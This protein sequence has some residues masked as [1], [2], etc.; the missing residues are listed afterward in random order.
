LVR[1]A[2]NTGRIYLARLPQPPATVLEFLAGRFAH[3]PKEEWRGR[4][5]RGQV[6]TDTGMLV[7]AQTPYQHGLTILYHRES[8]SEPALPFVETIVFEDEHLLVADKPHFLPVTP[9]G[10]AV[11]ECLLVRLQRR[12]PDDELAPLHRLDRDTAGIVV[13]SKR[14]EERKHYTALFSAHEVTRRYLAVAALDSLSADGVREWMVADR[15]TREPGSF[16]MRSVPGEANASTHVRLIAE[17]EGRG[18]F[19]LLPETGKKHQ[20]RL[21]MLA[22]GFP[23]MNDPLYPSTI[24]VGAGDFSRPLQLLAAELS[25]RDPLTHEEHS[26][27]SQRRL[28]HWE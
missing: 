15:L 17:R 19:E 10:E 5:E 26:F 13:F 24:Q 23:I 12:F 8:A 4:V 2:P 18:L 20:L 7:T 27:K 6:S 21:H 14:G 22:L 25:F 11:N 1:T 16:R 3:I 28:E 9:A